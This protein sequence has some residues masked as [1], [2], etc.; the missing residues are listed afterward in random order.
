MRLTALE[1]IEANR[2]AQPGPVRAYDVRGFNFFWDEER[3]CLLAGSKPVGQRSI[4]E[5][6]RWVDAALEVK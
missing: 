5:A 3:Q 4:L 6:T 2:D 1:M